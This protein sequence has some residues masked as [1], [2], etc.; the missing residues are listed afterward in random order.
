[1]TWLGKVPFSEIGMDEDKYTLLKE[2]AED[3]EYWRSAYSFIEGVRDRRL[4]SLTVRQSNWVMTID[5]ELGV[6]LN[7]R[8]VREVFKEAQDESAG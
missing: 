2:L 5:A 1:M 3:S 7:R 4:F 8:A 6:E